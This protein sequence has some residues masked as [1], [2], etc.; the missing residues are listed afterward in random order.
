MDWMAVHCYMAFESV[1][2][3]HQALLPLENKPQNIVLVVP[4]LA[5][6]DEYK[7]KIIN[8]YKNVYGE[9][10]VY[11]SIEKDKELPIKLSYRWKINKC[12]S[13]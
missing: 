8:Q 1:V 9:Y 11:L 2:Y 10:N 3:T 6:I 5:L 12:I 4:T 13:T 7:R